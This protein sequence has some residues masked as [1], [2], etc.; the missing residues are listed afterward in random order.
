[1][2]GS[3][4]ASGARRRRWSAPWP[5]F[6]LAC[7]TLATVTLGVSVARPK[8]RSTRA[9]S[10]YPAGLTPSGP[11]RHIV[12]CATAEGPVVCRPA[13]G[14]ARI[15][16]TPSQQAT[17]TAQ[18]RQILHTVST[19]DWCT[20]PDPAPCPILPPRVA[21]P[22]PG[23]CASPTRLNGIRQLVPGD[24]TIITA[25]LARAGYPDATLRID[26]TP[27]GPIITYVVAIPP[28]CVLGRLTTTHPPPG[29][30]ILGTYPNGQCT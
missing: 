14:W 1:M 18:A 25:A 4:D 11:V 12:G 15:D 9:V 2:V 5:V 20:A 13:G 16:L 19:I 10:G 24:V 21:C 3:P 23:P 7:V 29:Q 26:T 30:S 8:H 27:A 6:G 28:A 22:T 17:A